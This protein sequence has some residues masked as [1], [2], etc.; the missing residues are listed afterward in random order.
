[1]LSTTKTLPLIAI[2]PGVLLN[3]KS[4][5]DSIVKMLGIYFNRDVPMIPIDT[6]HLL[7]KTVF[8]PPLL[9]AKIDEI[10]ESTD[11]LTHDG[12][13]MT[14]QDAVAA[15]CTSAVNTLIKNKIETQQLTGS[16]EIPFEARKGQDTYY[17]NIMA[18]LQQS[19]ICMAQGSTG[20]GKSRAMIAAALTVSANR[21]TR[22]VVAAPTLAVLGESLWAE[23]EHL[24]DTGLGKGLKVRFFPG[25]SE[26]IDSPKLIE[27][28]KDAADLGEPIDPAV[29][30]WVKSKGPVLDETPLTR[31]MLATG[32][33]LRWLASDLRKIATTLDA[34]DFL[35]TSGASI[36][37]DVEAI[38]KAVRSDVLAA[39]VI[40]CTQAMLVYAQRGKWAWFP[41]PSVLILDEAHL[42]EGI[43]A[44]A[45]SD[46]LS[47]FSLRRSV[48]L[49][50]K[51]AASPKKITVLET[52]EL[53]LTKLIDEIARNDD[54]FDKVVLSQDSSNAQKITDC[55]EK[56]IALLSSS[57]LKS[58][59]LPKLKDAI[60][61]LKKATEALAGSHITYGAIEF[62]PDR[63][64]PAIFVGSKSVAGLIGAIWATCTG[65]GVA[66]SA[67]LSTLDEH[68]NAKFDYVAS[69]LAL[70][71]ARTDMPVPVVAPWLYTVPVLH[72]PKEPKYFTR[73][74]Y[75][76]RTE[77]PETEFA[78]LTNIALL[79]HEIAES[80]RGG[81]L[82]LLTSH[83]QVEV[84]AELLRNFEFSERIVA[85][86]SGEKFSV[87]EQRFREKY[88]EGKFPILLGVGSA[89]TGIDL[90]DKSV[91]GA[92]DL[93]LSDLIIGC[94]PV[95]LNR[96]STMAVRIERRGTDPVVKESLMMLSQGLGRAVRSADSAEKRIWI[97]DGRIWSAWAGMASLQKSAKRMLEKYKRQ[98]QF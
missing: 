59:G 95:G 7:R 73:P 24:R 4:A 55:L 32:I 16:V 70:P 79:T 97:A 98:E 28:I 60:E 84:V 36:G 38:I 65:G 88:Q 41:K 53:A 30:A 42:F 8:M 85:M 14:Y 10:V 2:P 90:T 48:K 57:V 87:T 40:F 11:M 93:L 22:V 86:K 71:P 68:G 83:A 66:A 37:S 54:G 64:F 6:T 76:L 12:K 23:Y 81:T 45:N 80:S 34:N 25:S 78:W 92:Y 72:V 20:I 52:L 82:L 47:L 29:Q 51:Q 61:A 21:K 91:S 5:S 49:A 50:T 58:V 56:V 89:W 44:N 13:A 26:F 94:M 17:R 74:D 77:H 43:V 69:L 75:K 31:A 1:M 46:R 27:Y 9:T 33:P 19:R 96:S 39:D 18:S 63:R 3:S 35:Y 67:T 62:S 15:M